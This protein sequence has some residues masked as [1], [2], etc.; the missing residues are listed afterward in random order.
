MS[1]NIKLVGFAGSRNL[2]V[3]YRPLVAKAVEAVVK[4][5]RGIAVGCSLGADAL[6][7]RACFSDDWGLRVPHLRVFAAFGPDGDGDWT[8][9]ATRLVQSVARFPQASSA[10]G[11]GRRI[12]VNWWAGGG[13]KAQ[14]VPRLKNRT[15]AMVQAVGASGEGHGLVAFVT[16][17]QNKSPGTWSAIRRANK[18]GIPVVVFP[19]GCSVKRFPALG[20]GQWVRAGKGI[21]NAGWRWEQDGPVSHD[22]VDEPTTAA[23]E[24]APAVSAD[25]KRLVSSGTENPPGPIDAPEELEFD[26][27]GET[28]HP[29]P[30]TLQE[31]VFHSL[32]WKPLHNQ[33]RLGWRGN[34]APRRTRAAATKGPRWAALAFLAIMP[35]FWALIVCTSSPYVASQEPPVSV[36]EYHDHAEE[37]IQA[38]IDSGCIKAT[39]Y[40]LMEIRVL[41]KFPGGGKLTAKSYRQYLHSQMTRYTDTWCFISSDKCL[42]A[43]FQAV[44]PPTKQESQPSRDPL[45]HPLPHEGE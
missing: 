9:S 3:E 1:D 27:A 19:C 23:V 37:Q 10:A 12:V 33:H 24:P 6:A 2:G 21:W 5:G 31:G 11:N 26:Y 13:S 41:P 22:A 25:A 8:G 42:E 29:A 4:D 32:G 18:Q 17:G 7:L 40:C 39:E 28:G 43:A 34:R 44:E 36:Q 35:F 16:G 20:K 45:T 30:N 15:K 38:L 14:L